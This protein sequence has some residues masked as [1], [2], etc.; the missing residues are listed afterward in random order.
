MAV[1]I[2]GRR[3]SEWLAGE[4]DSGLR[5]FAQRQMTGGGFATNN[6]AG[7]ALSSDRLFRLRIHTFPKKTGFR[8]QEAGI[9]F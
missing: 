5:E 7:A 6:R 9:S 1:Q 4:S 3:I 8:S 2:E